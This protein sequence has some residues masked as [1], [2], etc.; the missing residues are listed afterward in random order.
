M[1]LEESGER[2]AAFTVGRLARLACL[3]IAAYGS[4]A[5]SLPNLEKPQCTDARLAARRFYS[6]HFGND[7]KM[8]ADNLKIRE[9]YMTPE[10][11]SSLLAAGDSKFD[12]FTATDDYPKAF[13]VGSCT[14]DS[15]TAAT[16]QIL[17]LWKDAT[18]SEQKEVHADFVKKGDNWLIQSVSK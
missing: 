15:D 14:S 1:R 3:L 2:R 18:R 8:T 6:I 4:I 10:L 5:C 13:R 16:L 9:S 17:L 12:Y 11:Y 7:M